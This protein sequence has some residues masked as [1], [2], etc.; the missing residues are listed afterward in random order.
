MLNQ[1]NR[2]R[3][4]REP[5]RRAAARDTPVVLWVRHVPGIFKIGIDAAL[6]LPSGPCGIAI[7][8]TGRLIPLVSIHADVVGDCSDGGGLDT[9][10]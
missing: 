3:D 8:M 7:A 6:L 9:E 10:R 2:F 1:L 5:P 4:S